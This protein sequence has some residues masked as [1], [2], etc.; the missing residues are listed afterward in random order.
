MSRGFLCY[1]TI[2]RVFA[3]ITADSHTTLQSGHYGPNGTGE[4]AES[5]RGEVLNVTTQQ[6]GQSYRMGSPGLI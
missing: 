5:Q 4:Q 6:S 2:S 3:F 1:L